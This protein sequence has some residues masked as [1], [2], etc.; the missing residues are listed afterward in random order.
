MEMLLTFY[1]RIGTSVEKPSNSNRDNRKANQYIKSGRD[2]FK[3]R[4]PDCRK[5]QYSPCPKVYG[6]LARDT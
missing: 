1:T 4:V 5:F 6:G 2:K 3:V